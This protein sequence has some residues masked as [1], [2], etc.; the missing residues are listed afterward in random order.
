MSQINYKAI[1]SDID[2]TLTQ[3]SP[4]A[5]PSD[6]VTAS[7]KNALSRGF[8]VSLATGRPFFLVKYLINHLGSLGP[9]ITDNGAV[10]VDSKSGNVLW[11]A[12]L[13]SDEGNR[14]IE[15]VS[16]KPLYR[17]SLDTGGI[18]LPKSFASDAKI[19]KLSVHDIT[20]EEADEILSRVAEE[21]DTIVG[22]KAA[23]YQ[24]HELVDIYFSNANATKATAISRLIEMLGLEKAE[25]IGIGDGHND[26]P[27]LQACGLKVAMGNAVEE[28]KSIADYI[29]PSVNEDGLAHILEKYFLN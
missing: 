9:T 28:L 16:S 11:E 10:I 1:V 20:H 19:R 23:S 27:L 3:L 14:I 13:P 18:D 22:V 21:F 5:L 7:V 2:G 26:T 17:A 4:E 6:K 8:T 25:V 24:G 29:A 12:N 15:L